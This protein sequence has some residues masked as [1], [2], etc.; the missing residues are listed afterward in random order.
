MPNQHKRTRDTPTTIGSQLTRAE[1]KEF[2]K[3]IKKN[4][5][6]IDATLRSQRTKTSTKLI[7]RIV[8]TPPKTKNAPPPL[9]DFKE[10]EFPTGMHCREPIPLPSN[11]FDTAELERLLTVGEESKLSVD[12]KELNINLGIDFGTSCT[13]VIAR[14]PYEPDEPTIAIPAPPPCRVPNAPHLWRTI[15]WLKENGTTYMWP[16]SDTTVLDTLKQD[17]VIGKQTIKQFGGHVDSFMNHEQAAVAYLTYVI[18]YVRGWLQVH[19][20]QS[21]RDCSPVW[22]INIGMP[23]E[24]FDEPKIAESY[25]RVAAASLLLADLGLPIAADSTE[26]VL[27]ER[28]IV[29][30][31][32]TIQAAE[33]SGIAVVPEAAAEMTSFAKSER[34]AEGLYMLIDVGA[35][36]LDVSTFNLHSN[37]QEGKEAI[38]SFMAAKVRPLGVESYYWFHK[39]GKSKIDFID[40]C[41]YT[42]KRVVNITRQFRDPD[43]KRWKAGESVPIFLVGGGAKHDL[44]RSIVDNLDPW[45]K[46]SFPNDGISIVPLN[47]PNTLDNAGFKIDNARMGVAWGLSFNFNEIG[48]IHSV[49]ETEDLER[50]TAKSS[51]D[52]Y[53]GKEQM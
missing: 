37:L 25:R 1:R 53:I 23:T 29:R 33:E 50:K 40:Q 9:V 44:H 31:G 38:Y 19:Q 32:Q 43:S 26:L 6:R 5:S 30:A 34:R 7:P 46:R 21:F 28:E 42:L 12:G 8:K 18:R 16:V 15:L 51:R 2:Q 49:S 3:L 39:Q 11:E 48:E 52:K 22:R 45:M 4:Q 20:E 27:Q 17:L 13:K 24:K 47:F 41:N 36:T 14:F 35:L 10:W